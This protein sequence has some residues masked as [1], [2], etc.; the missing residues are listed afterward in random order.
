MKTRLLTILS[1]LLIA[2]MALP[3]LT[4]TAQAEGD[5]PIV[6][7]DIEGYV[8]YIG[9]DYAVI[10]GY[11]VYA[12]GA[13]DPA[14]LT[15]GDYVMVSAE[16]N[17]DGTFT[18]IGLE[19]DPTAPPQEDPEPGDTIVVVGPITITDD[20]IFVGDYEIAPAGAFNPS[21]LEDGDI[22]IIVGVLL[23]ED[24][25]QASSFFLVEDLDEDDDEDEEECDEEDDEDCEEDED[26]EDEDTGACTNL[27][28]VGETLAE[29]YEVDDEV[30]LD[31]RC[32]GY[33]YGE[34]ARALELAKL[35]GD[36]ADEI[37][38]RREDG[39][40]W[41]NILKDYD[42]HPSDLAPGRTISNGKNKNKNDDDD[43]EDLQEGS[44]GNGRGRGPK[45]NN[46]RGNPHND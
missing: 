13:F 11:V 20:G 29:A 40:G 9:E 32:D 6:T 2:V 4:P 18:A 3:V 5:D 46:G 31:W 27:N 39:E 44:R 45:G 34:I 10:D 25:V 42:I 15:V 12:N 28:P 43:P 41:G 7:M 22:V 30:I 19:V 33:G 23:N 26:D 17:D 37:L 1:I 36:D 16:M 35:S 14:D 38:A 21:S 24:T 8:Q